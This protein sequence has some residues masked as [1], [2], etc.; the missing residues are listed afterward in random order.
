MSGSF[1]ID[2]NGKPTPYFRY[3][4]FATLYVPALSLPPMKYSSRHASALCLVCELIPYSRDQ[5]IGPLPASLQ[6]GNFIIWM[7]PARFDSAGLFARGNTL[8]TFDAN[9][10]WPLR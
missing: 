5:P 6:P 4:S 2:M 8:P 1:S 3:Q 10:P 7:L 9:V